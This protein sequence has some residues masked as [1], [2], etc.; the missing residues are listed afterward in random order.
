[1]DAKPNGAGAPRASARSV[2]PALFREWNSLKRFIGNARQVVAADTKLLR[3]FSDAARPTTPEICGRPWPSYHHAAVSLGAEILACVNNA[4]GG[5]KLVDVPGSGPLP[6]EITSRLWTPIGAEF[7]AK[8]L[9]QWCAV[10][11][12]RAFG[13]KASTWRPPTPQY[14]GNFRETLTFESTPGD[15]ERPAGDS[16]QLHRDCFLMLSALADGQKSQSVHLQTQHAESGPT[17]PNTLSVNA[18]AV[19]SIIS[20]QP[21]GQGVSAKEIIAKLKSHRITITEATLRKHIMPVLKDGHG[22]ENR[23]AAGGYLI[24]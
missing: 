7:D 10:E 19:L 20:A 22:V 18:K 15:D 3:V 6:D 24:P 2:S 23:R 13:D 21:K 17:P 11:A 9:Q 5:A 8:C 4:I 1:M 16:E 14:S 12:E